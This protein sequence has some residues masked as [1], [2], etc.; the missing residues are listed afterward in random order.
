MQACSLETE[1]TLLSPFHCAAA[2]DCAGEAE[3]DLSRSAPMI[4][5]LGKN[6][7]GRVWRVVVRLTGD[8]DV[9]QWRSPV[10]HAGPL[11]ATFLPGG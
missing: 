5:Y 1:G 9:E 4:S 6:D 7:K 11:E 2:R 8:D 3:H 10:A